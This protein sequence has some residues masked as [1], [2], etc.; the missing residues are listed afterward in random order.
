MNAKKETL[1]FNQVHT[2]STDILKDIQIELRE[3]YPDCNK[4][5]INHFVNRVLTD[6]VKAILVTLTNAAYED[7]VK[8]VHDKLNL[9]DLFDNRTKY[10]N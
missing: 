9:N 10:L 4:Y 6:K 1:D 3:E 8:I 2:L 5:E 7:I